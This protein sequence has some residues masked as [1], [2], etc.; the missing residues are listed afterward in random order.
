MR[1]FFLVL[2][3][4]ALLPFCVYAEDA[5]L[6]FDVPSAAPVIQ[7]APAA[8]KAVP[9]TTKPAVKA[10]RNQRSARTSAGKKTSASVSK[11]RNSTTVAAKSKGVRPRE[12]V[13]KK[14]G[15]QQR[16][17]AS[18]AKPKVAKPGKPPAHKQQ[19]TRKKH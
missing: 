2:F 7:R 9:S 5:P 4:A 12:A 18:S 15:A 11:K 19:V 10:H 8:N 6:P 13:N 1:V 3:F 17:K 14:R 16:R